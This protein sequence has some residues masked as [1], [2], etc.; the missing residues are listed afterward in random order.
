M[1]CEK[2]D[3]LERE[4]AQARAR[5]DVTGELLEGRTKICPKDESVALSRALDQ[6][7]KELVGARVAVD[8]HLREHGGKAARGVYNLHLVHH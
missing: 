1:P 8:R 6:S 5:F 7:W 3:R 2:C 4:H